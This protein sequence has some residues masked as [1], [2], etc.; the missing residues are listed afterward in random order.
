[1]WTQ[2]DFPGADKLPWQLLIRARFVDEIDAIVAH[3]VVRTLA[4]LMAKD[5][6]RNLAGVAAKAVATDGAKRVE[7]SGDQRMSALGAFA[8]WDGEICPRWWP[9]P[10]FPPRRRWY[11]EF[12][13][14][15]IVLALGAV[16]ALVK[17]AGSDHL[18]DAL[19]GAI[20]GGQLRG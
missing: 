7:V 5:R 8:D 16:Q 3:T 2:D 11:G 17:G 4:P 19:D 14:P 15:A 20:G 18:A 10:P 9:R 1:M 13:D 6:A 12:D